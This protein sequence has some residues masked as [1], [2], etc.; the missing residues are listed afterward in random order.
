MKTHVPFSR[1]GFTLME[2]MITLAIFILLAGAAF[3]V[4]GGVLQGASALTDNQNHIDEIGALKAYLNRQI[5][6]LPA[7]STLT[8][9]QRGD[10]EGLVQNGIIYGTVNFATAI[11]A[12]IQPNGYYSLR[13]ASYETMAGSNQAQDARQVMQT[14]VTTDDPTL[15]WRLLVTDIKTLDWK[16]L[17]FNQTLWVELWSSG[18]KPNLCELSLQ[19]AGDVNPTTM[20]FWVPKLSNVPAGN[21]GGNR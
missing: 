14:S 18:T 16:F 6:T 12:K 5:V 9:Y 7:R 20:D 8:S 21:Q 3:G 4:L 13:V 19:L 10:G 15:D 17:D 11:D 1:S 2:M